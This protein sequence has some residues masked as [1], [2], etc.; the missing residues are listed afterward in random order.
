MVEE[1]T[2]EH[3]YGKPRLWLFSTN[4]V[5]LKDRDGIALSEYV[6]SFEY[7][8][9]EEEDDTCKIKL[10][11]PKPEILNLPY[12]VQDVVIQVMWGYVLPQGKV[13]PSPVRTIAVRDLKNKYSVK[14]IELELNCTD[15]VSYLKSFSTKT[16]PRYSRQGIEEQLNLQVQLG[17]HFLDYIDEVAAGKVVFTTIDEKYARRVDINGGVQYFEYD[18]K[19][20]TIG[21]AVDN[22]AVPRTF[23]N[24]FKTQRKTLG[25]SASINN[26]IEDKLKYL[27]S[28][29]RGSF[30]ANTTDRQL[31]IMSRNFNQIPFKD[32]T[33]A[34][35]NGELLSFSPRTTTRLVKENTSTNNVNPYTKST[36]N[37]SVGGV[38]TLET[39]GIKTLWDIVDEQKEQKENKDEEGGV[40][41]P[42]LKTPEYVTN[43]GFFT[44][45]TLSKLE[46]LSDLQKKRRGLHE[47]GGGYGGG[48]TGGWGLTVGVWRHYKP[49][50]S[51]I[52]PPPPDKGYTSQMLE[53]YADHAWETFLDDI[54]KQEGATPLRPFVFIK[55]RAMGM[56]PNLLGF[57]DKGRII[58]QFDI[59]SYSAEQVFNSIPEFRDIVDDKIDDLGIESKAEASRLKENALVGYVVEKIIRKYEG[60]AVVVGDPSLIKSRT[61]GM[62][63]L[64]NLD[65]GIWYATKVTHKIDAKGG[66]ITELGL[67]KKPHPVGISKN[68]YEAKIDH[69]EEGLTR[70]GIVYQENQIIFNPEN[71]E[72]VDSNFREGESGIE[73]RLELLYNQ[74]E[75]LNSISSQANRKR[76]NFQPEDKPN[77]DKF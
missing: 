59:M 34:G 77:A 23:Y 36:E 15:L 11:L 40:I 73:Q 75:I 54:D 65:T 3:S 2:F 61:Y 67:I 53:D 42:V 46:D 33:W 52:P 13:L 38:D 14:G 9:D 35:G 51:I 27:M 47:I 29:L 39:E 69:E 37:I 48:G 18:E 25:H 7:C 70:E 62:K 30:L 10:I 26:A 50:D 22:T 31:I 71:M 55:R 28:K 45:G 43:R 49:S 44:S 64:S 24:N 19:T 5:E 57:Y 1:T 60:T 8:Y 20:N 6:I 4:G 16:T 66:Y 74:D 63:N 32:F 41:Q 17:D 56:D 58:S 76:N 72:D 12:L 68:V 21:K